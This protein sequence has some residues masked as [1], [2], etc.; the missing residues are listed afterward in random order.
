MFHPP[1]TSNA[2]HIPS[3][4]PTEKLQPGEIRSLQDDIERLLMITESLWQILKEKH[5]YSDDELMRRVAMIDLADGKLDGRVAKSP[6]VECPGCHRMLHKRHYTCV[7]C[8]TQV[9]QEPFRR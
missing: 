4:S 8:G 1:I 7:Y 3:S 5:G 6:P 2:Q 9:V